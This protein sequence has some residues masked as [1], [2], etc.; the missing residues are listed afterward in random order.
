[1]M[2]SVFQLAEKCQDVDTMLT[3]PGSSFVQKKKLCLEQIL[4]ME[5]IMAIKGM[6]ADLKLISSFFF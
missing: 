2:R 1:M 6:D 5:N 4:G 3:S